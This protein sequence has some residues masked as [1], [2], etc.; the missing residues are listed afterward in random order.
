MQYGWFTGHY[1]PL[2]QM[3]FVDFSGYPSVIH[4][5]HNQA[6]KQAPVIGH[7]SGKLRF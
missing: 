6:R 7:L 2:F 1:L 5:S 4:Y 3:K